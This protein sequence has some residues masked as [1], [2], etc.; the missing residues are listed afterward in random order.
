MSRVDNF[1]AL[2]KCELALERIVQFV[3]L[4]QIV[5]SRKIESVIKIFLLL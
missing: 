2:R 1:R 5:E 3:S 4:E